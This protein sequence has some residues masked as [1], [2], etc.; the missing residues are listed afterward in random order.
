[1]AGHIAAHPQ[2]VRGGVV[3]V[4]ACVQP[5]AAIL[6]DKV[7][8]FT[9]GILIHREGTEACILQVDG[10]GVGNVSGQLVVARGELHNAAEE[11]IQSQ[12][13]AAGINA[14]ADR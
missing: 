8:Q 10:T 11:D 1:M 14:A 5:Q 12:V 13:I 2:Q 9:G 4:E 3:A 7:S 6:A